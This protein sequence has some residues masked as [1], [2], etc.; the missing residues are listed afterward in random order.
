MRHAQKCQEPPCRTAPSENRKP[1]LL[2]VTPEEHPQAPG[3][4]RALETAQARVRQAELAGG[5]LAARQARR[6]ANGLR[7]KLRPS[8]AHWTLVYDVIRGAGR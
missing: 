5:Y 1:T 8:V 3:L 6:L 4:A 2:H 7:R